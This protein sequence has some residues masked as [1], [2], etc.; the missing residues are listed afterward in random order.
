M[1]IP[2][3]YFHDRVVLVLFS[4][5]LLLA[6][7]GTLLILLRIDNSHGA[8]YFVQYRAH[9]GSSAF[10]FTKGSLTDVLGFIGF[11]ALV[12]VF[13]TILSMRLYHTRRHVSIAILGLGTLL[14]TLTVIVSNALL[15]YKL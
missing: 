7:I 12:L 6:S 5:N 1:S 4:V 2:K 13:H 15:I 10:A 3:N 14:L 8:D 9:L 11:L